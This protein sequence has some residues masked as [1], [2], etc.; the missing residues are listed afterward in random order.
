MKSVVTFVLGLVALPVLGLI[1]GVFGLLPSRATP[2][3]PHW[4]AGFAM[5]ALDASLEKRAKGVTNPIKPGDKL[6]IAAGAKLYEQQCSGCHGDAKGPSSWGTND[7]YPRV[8]QF[9]QMADNDLTPEE[10]YVA[11]HDGIRYSGMAAWGD[12]IPNSDI[13]KLAN[14]VPTIR[15]VETPCCAKP[16]KS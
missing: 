13:W 12:Q 2:N 14:F 1:A 16:A 15:R 6:T 7:F 5:R 8:P 4:E 9:Y 11:I 3:P 10:A